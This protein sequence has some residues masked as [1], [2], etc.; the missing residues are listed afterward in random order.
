L[1]VHDVEAHSGLENR[2]IEMVTRISVALAD[3]VLVFSHNQNDALYRRYKKNGI[4]THLPYKSYFESYK[5][6]YALRREPNTILFFGTIR[7]NKGLEVLIKAA[8]LA[9]QTIPSLKVIIAGAC[10]DFSFYEEFMRAPQMYELHIDSIPDED[11]GSFFLRSQFLVLPYHDATQS[12]PLLISLGFNCPVVA[13]NV[14]GLPEYIQ[15][16]DT[17]LLFEKDNYV[18]L[19]ET[20]ISLLTHDSLLTH[21]Q[22]ISRDRVIQK[23]SASNVA[24]ELANILRS[25]H[26]RTDR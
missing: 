18:Q 10:D 3:D 11:V 19:S 8:E 5:K 15:P 20:I 12:G 17:G 2:V 26:T 6:N 9:R 25:R 1:V 22:E 23:F 16:G 24:T 21:M 13:S 7:K 14:G 4:V